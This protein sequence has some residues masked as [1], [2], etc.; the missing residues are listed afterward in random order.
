MMVNKN[1]AIYYTSPQLASLS[2]FN[3]EHFTLLDIYLPLSYSENTGCCSSQ[4]HRK[5]GF[6]H[7]I[8]ELDRILSQI[9]EDFATE[10]KML[11][12]EGNSEPV[13]SGDLSE[14][15]RQV[16][17]ALNEYKKAIVKALND[18]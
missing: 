18:K 3:A 10:T 13:T 14:L 6:C 5:G 2:S 12:P 15:S 8:S 11:F 1:D 9:A 7:A 17:Y 16:F 4:V